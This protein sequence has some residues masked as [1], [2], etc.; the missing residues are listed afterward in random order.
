[1]LATGGLSRWPSH[2]PGDGEDV[3]FIMKCVSRISDV[4]LLL[5]FLTDFP[6]SDFSQNV[7]TAVSP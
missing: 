2:G 3:F 4:F 5:F 7:K 6:F 1:M